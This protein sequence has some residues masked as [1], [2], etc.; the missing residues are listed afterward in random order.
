MRK[1]TIFAAI[2]AFALLLS[3]PHLSAQVNVDW[4]TITQNFAKPAQW[5]D[6]PSWN[7]LGKSDTYLP[8]FVEYYY[9]VTD[10]EVLEY[11]LWY[12]DAN[13][14]Y[15]SQTVGK[16]TYDKSMLSS[17]FIK[18]I[19]LISFSADYWN[20][21]EL[22]VGYDENSSKKNAFAD[23]KGANALMQKYATPYYQ[24]RYKVAENRTY[25]YIA[26]RKGSNSQE[27]DTR[28][29]SNTIDMFAFTSKSEADAFLKKLQAAL[30]NLIED[31]PTPNGGNA[32]PTGNW[33]FSKLWSYDANKVS[34]ET[35]QVMNNYLTDLSF[36]TQNNLL[37]FF[38][39]NGDVIPG[40]FNYQN[41]SLNLDFS[42]YA[43]QT[44]SSLKFLKSYTYTVEAQGS[45][46][47]LHLWNDA[48]GGKKPYYSLAFK[49]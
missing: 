22:K 27:V 28:Q 45:T 2:T 43:N 47:V 6:V 41:T 17:I 7:T 48:N 11:A 25:D 19:P 36:N 39:A 49:R 18:R 42:K 20:T 31:K 3:T 46:L 44:N 24:I 35:A 4:P 30:Q 21:W 12:S 34:K 29:G 16:A 14:K 33:T 1:N 26:H 8:L 15:N 23:D 10:A 13:N 9:E 32:A 5:L 37:T 38:F 40:K